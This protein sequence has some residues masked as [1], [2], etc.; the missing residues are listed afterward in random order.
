MTPPQTPH[1]KTK[2]IKSNYNLRSRLKNIVGKHRAAR[3]R[4]RPLQANKVSFTDVNWMEPK[5]HY[6]I[7][8]DEACRIPIPKNLKE[9]MAHPQWRAAVIKEIDSIT[10]NK[11]FEFVDA[12]KLETLPRRVRRAINKNI[13]CHFVFRAKPD[14]NGKLLKFKARLVAN[15]NNQQEGINY[16]SSFAPVAAASTIKGQIVHGLIN[17]HYLESWDYSSA[18]LNGILQEIIFIALPGDPAEYGIVIPNGCRILLRKSIYGLVQA[19]KVW[20]DLLKRSLENRGFTQCPYEPGLFVKRFEDGSIIVITTYVDDLL[21][22]AS[23]KEHLDEEFKHLGAD[24]PIGNREELSWHLG[25]HFQRFGDSATIDQSAYVIET[26][27][28]F[29]MANAKGRRTPRKLESQV[30]KADAPKDEETFNEA[31]KLPFRNLVGKLMYLS[32]TSRPDIS[33]AI[34]ESSKYFSNWGAAHWNEAKDILRY[35]RTS[36]ELPL[37]YHPKRTESPLE[38]YVDAAYANDKDTRRSQTGI[39]IFY[40]D[41]LIGWTSRRQ[42][43]VSLSSCEAEYIALTDAAKDAIH[44]RRVLS[45]IDNEF[46]L[47]VPTKI[48]EDNQGTIALAYSD[49][50]TQARTKHIDIRMH[51][52]RDYISEG[53]IDVQWV[54]TDAQRADFFTKP[55]AGPKHEK[56]RNLNM[57]CDLAPAGYNRKMSPEESEAYEQTGYAP[58]ELLSKQN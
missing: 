56:M 51:F 40:Y 42:K 26:I 1:G 15:G 36:H 45:F 53:I 33:E 19:G 54:P 48:Y 43:S 2:P 41:C 24:L 31:Q 30:T 6:D 23:S 55:L 17:H 25:M 10:K 7:G 52:V 58:G 34:S 29:N 9:A 35:L 16:F 39:A 50:K 37:V 49:G 5:D 32:Q 3:T 14:K 20:N 28:Q 12:T 44:L 47:D 8:I 27:N 21:V 13:R 22:S 46:D 57:S 38:I 18:Y 4:R 11:T